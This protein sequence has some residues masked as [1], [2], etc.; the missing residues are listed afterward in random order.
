MANVHWPGL[1]V[2]E[3]TLTVDST[4][5]PIQAPSTSEKMEVNFCIP[6]DTSSLLL[7][8]RQVNFGPGTTDQ[9]ILGDVKV[10]VE[11]DEVL[12]VEADRYVGQ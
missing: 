8:W 7:R 10:R 12:K 6:I 4:H 9:W 5:I 1:N 2:S 11:E 3:M